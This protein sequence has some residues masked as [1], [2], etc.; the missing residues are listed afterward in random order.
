MANNIYIKRTNSQKP[1]SKQEFIELLSSDF[2][3]VDIY[4]NNNNGVTS[5]VIVSKK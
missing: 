2:E 5:V 4:T 3:V 1:F